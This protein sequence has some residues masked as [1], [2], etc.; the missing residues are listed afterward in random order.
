MDRLVTALGG[1]A[2]E[3]PHKVECCGGGLSLSRTDVVV[4]LTE[5]ILGMARAAGAGCIV[6]ACPMCQINLDMRQLDIEKQT[7]KSYRMPVVYIT[8]LLGLCLGLS[9]DELGF[10][11]LMI[12][13]ADVI[14]A[15]GH[16]A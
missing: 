10:D 8:Q 7:G 4:G 6:V 13:A 2:L 14:Q 5:S 16:A 11:K 15:V 12:S 3:W 1:R 9:P